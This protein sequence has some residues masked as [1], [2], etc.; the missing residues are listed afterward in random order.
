[1]KTMKA[2]SVGLVAA[3]MLF[4][5]SIQVTNAGNQSNPFRSLWKAVQR[6]QDQINNIE[7]IPGP[8]GEAGPQGQPGPMGLQ[9]LTGNTGPQGPA[10]I[11]GTNGID[12]VNGAPGPQGLQ[13]IQGPTG[14]S[15]TG[16]DKARMYR[17]QSAMI[18]VPF[19]PVTVAEAACD[20]G[21][22]IL[23][24]GGFWGSHGSIITTASF[25][26]PFFPLPTWTVGATT[27]GAPGEMMAVAYCY[28]VD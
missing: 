21:N 3:V 17:T 18:P 27:V 12:G 23:I 1:M 13:G 6:L 7:L 10:G 2:L 24:S 20:D 9:G 28:R 25:P 26:N 19:G 16:L 4:A 14:P 8:P 5:G 22:D 11:N 15:G